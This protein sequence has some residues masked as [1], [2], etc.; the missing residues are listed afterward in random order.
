MGGG[1]RRSLNPAESHRR[2]QKRRTAERKKRTRQEALARVP[3]ARRD[4]SKLLVEIERLRELECEGRL[5]G[6]ARMRRKHLEDQFAALCRAQQ[7]AGVPTLVLPDYDPE[8]YLARLCAARGSAG[9]G[10]AAPEDN[11]DAETE[12]D[13]SALPPMP[14]GEPLLGGVPGLPAYRDQ[15]QPQPQPQTLALPKSRTVI[16]AAPRMVGAAALD[17]QVR[18]FLH[19]LGA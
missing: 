6:D 9:A 11:A 13:A 3:L 7:K 19:D 16:S 15:P 1:G 10:R 18:E 5:G 2:A 12:A 14:P 17:A 8:A 4:P